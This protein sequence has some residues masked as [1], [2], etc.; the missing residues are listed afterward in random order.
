MGREMWVMFPDDKKAVGW[1]L[2]E[3]EERKRFLGEMEWGLLGASYSYLLRARRL[4]QRRSILRDRRS[5][6]MLSRGRKNVEIVYLC[7]LNRKYVL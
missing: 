1:D 6:R 2:I 7:I 3:E 5:C 4:S